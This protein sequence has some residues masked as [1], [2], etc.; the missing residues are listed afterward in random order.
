M[1]VRS[2]IALVG[3]VFLL[4]LAGC[5]DRRPEADAATADFT[6]LYPS[7]EVVSIRM[8]EDEVVARSFAVTYRRPGDSHTRTLKIQ[9]L[10]NDRGAYELRPA[11]PANLP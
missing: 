3:S 6:R 2:F 4:A 9:Y 5:R 7:A 8:S 11:P 1:V 10:K